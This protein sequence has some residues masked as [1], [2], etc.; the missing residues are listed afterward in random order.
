M[1]RTIYEQPDLAIDLARAY[2]ATLLYVGDPERERYNVSLPI[3]GVLN[4]SM[5]RK[6]VQIYRIPA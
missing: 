4:S 5:M 2:N 3:G 6:G 1:L